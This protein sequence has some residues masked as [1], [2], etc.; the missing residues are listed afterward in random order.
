MAVEAYTTL[1]ESLENFNNILGHSFKMKQLF[2]EIKKVALSPTSTV[3]VL[4]ES[5]TG[6]EL[7]AR[8]IHN[9]G[10][11]AN[12]PF[13]EI[14]CTAV[15][16]NLMETELFGYEPGA[17]TDAKTLKKGL[18]ELS[19]GGTFFMDEIGDLNVNLQAKLLK[20]L[21]EKVFR[22]VGGVKNIEVKMRIITATN[23][24]LLKLVQKGL[25][26]ED[27][28][29]RLNVITIRVPALRERNF[30][31]LFLADYFMYRLAAEH[32]RN[33]IGL[34]LDAKEL[35]MGY[36]WP[37][38]VREL[39]NT[40]ERAVLMSS[41]EIIQQSDL[42]LGSGHI[43]ND[44]PIVPQNSNVFDINITSQG[45]SLDELEKLVIKKALNLANGNKAEAARLLNIGREK[46]K[47]R[48]R[49]YNIQFQSIEYSDT[50]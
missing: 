28:Y 22:R 7:V 10:K 26:R 36:P 14:N 1:N 48:M 2:E 42:K 31:I 45:I 23:R 18:L 35:L 21:D 17:F 50:L 24:D 15:P 27:L 46:L 25:F 8:A 11:N 43:N 16:N 49:K 3:L 34:A 9:A 6:K 47:Y 32:K 13:V 38:N 30:D 5:G 40:I 44:F 20:V 4:G 41:S 19:D 12:Q 37:G 33:I 29:Y 39:K